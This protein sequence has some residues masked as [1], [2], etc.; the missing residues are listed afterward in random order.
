M[1]KVAAPVQRPTRF[2]LVV[3]MKTA[4]RLG[5]TVPTSILLRG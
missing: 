1:T 2:Q 5:V 3:I 4:S